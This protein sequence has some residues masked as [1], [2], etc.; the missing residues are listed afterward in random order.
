MRPLANTPGTIWH[1][2]VCPDTWWEGEGPLPPMPLR[3]LWASPN[4]YT[5]REWICDL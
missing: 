2:L 4:P 1:G 3:F 5:Y